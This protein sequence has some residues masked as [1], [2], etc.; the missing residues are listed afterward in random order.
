[1][2]ICGVYFIRNLANDK[3]YVGSSINIFTRW[4]RHK[5]EL[6]NKKHHSEKLQRAFEKYGEINF[7]F[8]LAESA[9]NGEQATLIEQKWINKLDS[10]VNGYNINPFANNVG[11]MPKSE[12]HKRKIGA[13]HLGR[14]LSE[15]SKRKIGDCHL[16][17]IRGPMSEETKRNISL[18]KIGKKPMT[19]EGKK[20]LSDFRKSTVGKKRGSYKP[21][22]N[23]NS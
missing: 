20:K 11:L 1:M 6:K 2:R 3:V 9:L 15:E 23:S 13:A 8:C 18:S 4:K 22:E 17:K 7:E 21:R 5:Y 16:G 12:E 19:E 14:K 10:F